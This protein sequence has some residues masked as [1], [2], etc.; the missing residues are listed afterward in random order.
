MENQMEKNMNTDIVATKFISRFSGMVGF[1]VVLDSL[2][3]FFC[4]VVCDTS[5]PPQIML[6]ISYAPTVPWRLTSMT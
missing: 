3:N 1:F 5:N 4:I 2:S 6:E